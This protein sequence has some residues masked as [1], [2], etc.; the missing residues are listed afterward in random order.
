MNRLQAVARAA[1]RRIT[2]V[3]RRGSVDRFNYQKRALL[4]RAFTT[5]DPAPTRFADLGGIWAVDGAYTFDLLKRYPVESAWLV[6]TDITDEVR[7]K[8]A[9]HPQLT[10]LNRNFGEPSL[11]AVIGPVDLV[12]LFDVLLHQVAPDWDDILARYAPLTR[13]FAI[14]NQQ[15][16]GSAET[17][18]LLDLGHEAYFANVPHKASEPLYQGLFDRLEEPHPEHDRPW[19]DIHNIWQWGITDADLCRKMAE[20]DF[21]ETHFRNHGQYGFL[22]NFENH[23]F[24]F[25]KSA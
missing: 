19:R 6:D 14:Y 15:W 12:I 2:T 8:Q 21:D 25:I 20:L 3:V 18:R 1:L 16:V 5:L 17:V 4:D 13:A 24:L 11:P 7:R 22:K 9:S 10:L 23:A